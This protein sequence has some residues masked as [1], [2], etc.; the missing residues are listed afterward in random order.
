MLFAL[1]PPN[2]TG[3]LMKKI[4]V[5]GGCGFIGSHLV[6]QLIAMDFEVRVIDNLSTGKVE[7]LHP[8]AELIVGDI[9]DKELMYTVCQDIDGC[10]HLAAIASVQKSVEEWRDTHNINQSGTVTILEAISARRTPMEYPFIYA[11]SAAVYGDNAN[12][13]LSENHTT[14]PL[15]PYG[16]DKYA[17]EHHARVAY[18]THGLPSIGYRFFNVYGPRQDP[19][20]PYSG[21]ISIFTDNALQGRDLV[22]FGDGQQIRDF[23]YVR[24]VVDMLVAGLDPSIQDVEIVNACTGR[25]STIIDIVKTLSS[26]TQKT[27]NTEFLQSRKGDIRTSLGD[28]SKAKD[29]LNVSAKTVLQEGLQH[30]INQSR[31][32]MNTG[33]TQNKDALFEHT[34][35]GGS[36]HA[37]H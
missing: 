7:N 21:V 6:D 11:S 27:L 13:P 2:R 28:P 15:T 32:I 34:G 10:F 19:L 23:I 17:C 4:L 5:T 36:S 1:Y 12:M 33:K 35:G 25:Q 37:I 31:D 9:C 16:V 24:D 18:I 29:L 30:L 8:K 22:I 3:A 26:I 14:R 20:S